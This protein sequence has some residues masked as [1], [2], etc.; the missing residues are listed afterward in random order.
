[1]IIGA[2]V[3]RLQLVENIQIADDG[4]AIRA[5][6]V[7]GFKQA[8]AGAAAGIILAHV[9]FA[10]DDIEFLGEFIRR[11]RGVLHDV[12]QNINRRGRAGVRHV[13]VIHRAVEARVGVHVT[14]G[15]LHFLVNPAAGARR[16]AFEQHV[17]EHVRQAGAEPFALVNAAGHRPC[18]RGNDRRAVVFA[19]DDDEAVFERG[20]GDAGGQGGG[21]SFE[22][23]VHEFVAAWKMDC[24]NSVE[25]ETWALFSS[26]TSDMDGGRNKSCNALASIKTP[27]NPMMRNPSRER[28]AGH[29]LHQSTARPRVISL[30]STMASASPASSSSQ[31]RDNVPA[32]ADVTTLNKLRQI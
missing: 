11:Q 14:A 16:R 4:E 13:N 17:F 32:I 12:A 5:A 19:H 28:S 18:L 7:G 3:V 24:L 2:D 8:A 21:Y 10:A 6:R 23:I 20:E 1:M 30:A 15:F 22:R 31:S 26:L 25:S 29:Q 9:H 27:S